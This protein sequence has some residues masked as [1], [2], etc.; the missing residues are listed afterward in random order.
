MIHKISKFVGKGHLIKLFLSLRSKLRRVYIPIKQFLSKEK[1]RSKYGVFFKKNWK[2]LTF[3]FYINASYGYFYWNRISS[4]SQ[5]FI[6]IDIGANQ[7]LYT[8]CA[9]S[10]NYCDKVYAFEPVKNTFSYLKENTFINNLNKKCILINKGIS[11]KKK[12]IDVSINRNHSGA[13]N[14]RNGHNEGNE[15]NKEKI[16]LINFKELN[17]LVKY[18]KGTKIIV[19]I[20]VEGHE[21]SVLKTLVLSDLI[22]D[23]NEILYEVDE[24]W[25]DPNI[26]SNLLKIKGFN[27]FTKVGKN[28]HYDVLAQ[29]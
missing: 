3:I 25:V 12:T 4:I 20:D 10:N 27:K 17:D 22:N 13:A 16:D 15:Y 28:K 29:K 2:D 23:I 11:D 7:G 1:I 21:E 24:D 6:F 8:I 26:L 14:L 19:K 5:R 18:E 9:A